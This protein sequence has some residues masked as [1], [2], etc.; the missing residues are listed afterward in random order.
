LC[1]HCDDVALLDVADPSVRRAHLR[2]G[3]LRGTIRTYYMAR[4]AMQ[5]LFLGILGGLAFAGLF[6]RKALLT[7]GPTRLVMI[8]LAAASVVGGPLVAT[9]L[10]T[11]IVRWLT[12]TCRGRPIQLRD[13]RVVR[14]TEPVTSPQR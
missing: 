14:N 5:M 2:E 3:D 9:I 10:G 13:V 4:S 8:G 7:T 11:R 12:K 1:I 6:T